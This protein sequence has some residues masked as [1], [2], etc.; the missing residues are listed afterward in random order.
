MNTILSISWRV[1]L[2]L[3]PRAHVFLR[4]RQRNSRPNLVQLR[5]SMQAVILAVTWMMVG[6]LTNVCQV[7]AAFDEPGPELSPYLPA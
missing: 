7:V 4:S 5:S 1:T 6:T 2:I 3:L